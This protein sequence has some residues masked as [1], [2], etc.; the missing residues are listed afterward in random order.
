MGKTIEIKG[1]K[2]MVHVFQDDRQ[3]TKKT[4]KQIKVMNVKM[5]TLN[6]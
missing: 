6:K 1:G 4:C 5:V 3:T 2:E